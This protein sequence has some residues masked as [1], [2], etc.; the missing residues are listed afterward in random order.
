M[1]YMYFY[2]DVVMTRQII[3]M[4]VMF[5]HVRAEWRMDIVVL[6]SCEMSEIQIR[7][8]CLVSNF[9]LQTIYFSVISNFQLFHH[10]ILISLNF[11]FWRGTKHSRY[12]LACYCIALFNAYMICKSMIIIHSCCL[13]IENWLLYCWSVYL[14]LAIVK[15]YCSISLFVVLA[16]FVNQAEHVLRQ[17][18]TSQSLNIANK[19]KYLLRQGERGWGEVWDW[20]FHFHGFPKLILTLKASNQSFHCPN[21]PN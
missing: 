8:P 15:N 12:L 2:F 14:L 13:L 10:I 19:K 21:L 16:H 1:Y 20:F 11:Q 17:A 18:F 7:W 3:R 6:S 9:F 4:C 5:G